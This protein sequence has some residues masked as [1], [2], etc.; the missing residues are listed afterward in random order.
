MHWKS[1]INMLHCFQW[2]WTGDSTQSI[3]WGKE[4]NNFM[5]ITNLKMTKEEFENFVDIDDELMTSDVRTTKDILADVQ[6][7]LGGKTWRKRRGL[8]WIWVWRKWTIPNLFDDVGFRWKSGDHFWNGRYQWWC[9][10]ISLLWK[11][12]AQERHSEWVQSKLK[13]YFK[14]VDKLKNKCFGKNL[15]LYFSFLLFLLFFKAVVQLENL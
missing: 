4:V 9:F 7:N 12:I 15:F 1:H 6:V 11:T 14:Y 10:P 3:L 13:N 2:G 8:W 5:L